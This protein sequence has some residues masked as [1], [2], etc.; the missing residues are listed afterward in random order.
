MN[1]SNDS[2]IILTR[3]EYIQDIYCENLPQILTS[4]NGIPFKVL[5]F[6][7]NPGLE[8]TFPWLSQVAQNYDEYKIEKLTFGFKSTITELG[9]SNAKGQCGAIALCTN[10]NAR[11]GVFKSK[12][13]MLEYGGANS[14]KTTDNI[15]HKVNC[16]ES[17][18]TGTANKYVRTKSVTT[19]QN[20]NDY[21]LGN[22]QLAISNMPDKYYGQSLGQL[23][24]SYRIRLHK[25]KPYTSL[26]SNVQQDLYVTNTA[27]V[28]PDFPLGRVADELLKGAQNNLGTI[29]VQNVQSQF[30]ILF[31]QN[32]T[33]YVEVIFQAS[34]N[35]TATLNGTGTTPGY[36]N[37]VT[38]TGN[39]KNVKDLYG[40]ANAN[41]TT[42]SRLAKGSI[43]SQ[44]SGKGTFIFIAHFLVTVPLGGAPTT[45]FAQIRFNV[46]PMLLEAPTPANAVFTQCS[47]TIREYNG[48]F[49]FKA[50]NEL[51]PY[52]QDVQNLEN[53]D[54]PMLINEFGAI[55]TPGVNPPVPV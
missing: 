17:E 21:D 47:L 9:D 39:I 3:T 34:L 23:W 52:V 28:R 13:T 55:Y 38:L 54:A 37:S 29:I 12:Q 46:S 22:F 44:Q 4:G 36:I 35:P 2:S 7:I 15:V 43:L 51:A 30:D 31:R 40:A 18:N 19:N 11:E 25:A 16:Y 33:G 32:Y 8:S 20:V 1:S 41:P 24:V 26:A 45:T 5:N 49:S 50:N 14:C 27:N 6:P 10:Y 48:G 42:T 53:G